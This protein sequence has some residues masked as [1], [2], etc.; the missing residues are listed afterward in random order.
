MQLFKNGLV[1]GVRV[2]VRVRFRLEAVAT[3]TNDHKWSNFKK[4]NK[5][6]KQN[7]EN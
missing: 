3:K 7:L 4:T 2:R 1:L 6:V 5:L